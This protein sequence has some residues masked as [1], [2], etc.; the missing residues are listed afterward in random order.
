[1]EKIIKYNPF[2]TKDYSIIEKEDKSY[3]NYNGTLL[4]L[5]KTGYVPK[6]GL[7]YDM[8]LNKENCEGKDVLDLGCG[9]L[10]I[11]GVI[12]ASNGAKSIESIDCDIECVKWFNKLIK[13]NGFD[14]F[15]CS[16]SDYY[17]NLGSKLYDVILANPPQMPMI[18]GNVHDS[19]DLDG[20]KYILQIMEESLTHLRENG[21]LYILLFDFLGIDIRTNFEP[22]LAEIALN[23]GYKNYTIEYE[24]DKILKSG[25]TYDSIPYINEVYPLYNFYQSEEPK[26][27]IKIMK[28]E[29]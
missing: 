26:C 12:A 10:G 15:S 1:M 18:N 7:L 17:Q 2:N 4:E 19:G 14:N 6:S 27:K 24:V 23:M 20:R 8:V 13:D 9:Y 28:L 5:S 11:L 25:V 29:K 22:S 16:H 3:F 21:Q